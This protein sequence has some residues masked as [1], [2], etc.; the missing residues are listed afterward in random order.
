MDKPSAPCPFC[1]SVDT[2][3]ISLFGSQVMTMQ[4][5]CRACGS[6]FEASKY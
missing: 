1:K 3:V 4:C 2:E 5:K 6:F